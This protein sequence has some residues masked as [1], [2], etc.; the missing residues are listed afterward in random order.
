MAAARARC[1]RLTSSGG[2]WHIEE[3]RWTDPRRSPRR[4]GDHRARH[5]VSEFYNGTQLHMVAWKTAGTLYWVS[6]TLDNEI[7]SNA[8]MALACRSPA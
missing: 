3:T 2:Y 6:N 1:G 8:M 5:Q 4:R 7:A